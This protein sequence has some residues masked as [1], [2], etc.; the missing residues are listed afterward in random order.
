[1]FFHNSMK[2]QKRQGFFLFVCLVG[3]VL[4]FKRPLL[5]GWEDCSHTL[6]IRW[7][8]S[9]IKDA[10]ARR[11]SEATMSGM[12][13]NSCCPSQPG[14]DWTCLVTLR[15]LLSL[16][17]T[18]GWLLNMNTCLFSLLCR[19]A[20]YKTLKD[21]RV[22]PHRPCDLLCCLLQRLFPLCGW[23]SSTLPGQ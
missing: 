20:S 18:L 16:Q 12:Q 22:Q 4:F 7:W 3:F 19:K 9:L 23:E 5:K 1:M 2:I 17:R 21:K 14:V 13:K 10:A 11:H 6:P 8:S 15:N